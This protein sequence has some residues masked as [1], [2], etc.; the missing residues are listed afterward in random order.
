LSQQ[1]AEQIAQEFTDFLNEFH[2]YNQPYDD[3]MDMELHEQYAWVLREQ[4][5]WGYFPF[6]KGVPVFGPSSAGKSERELYEKVRKSPK[7]IRQW[8]PHQRRWTAL[9]GDIGGMIQREIMLA[10]RHFEKFTGKAPRFKFARTD[11]GEP[12]FEHFTKVLHYIDHDGARFGL[13]GLSDGILEYTTDDG[14]VLRVGLEVKSKQKSY[15]DIKRLNQPQHSHAIQTVS[16]SEMYGLDYFI[17]LYVSAAKKDWFEY[18]P[19][20]A[21]FGKHITQADRD[22]LKS[23]ISGVVN[24]AKA[25][26]PPDV[27]LF[28]HRF[29]DYK[30]HIARTLTDDELRD[31]KHQVRQAQKGNLQAWKKQALLNA[32]YEI[33][34]VRD[35]E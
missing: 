26:V 2:S 35:G 31:L 16:Y 13:F 14:E 24:A 34:E 17:V 1:L 4:A 32:Y 7:D 27:D 15:A 25:G 22:S 18:Y 6:E 9:G 23:K 33:Q 11:R 10:E 12:Q 5:Q 28:E 19:D 20:I 30:T 3:R 8:L 29:N 21:A